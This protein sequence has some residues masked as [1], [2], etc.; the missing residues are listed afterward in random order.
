MLLALIVIPRGAE[1][2]MLDIDMMG[3]TKTKCVFTLKGLP[4][5]KKNGKRTPVLEFDNFKED[6]DLCPV[7]S[8]IEYCCLT[9]PFRRTNKETSLF[10]A[11]LKPHMA[12]SKSSI[13]RWLKDVLKWAGI[14][15]KI[16]QAHS[17]RAAATS[18]AFMKGLSV[19][20]IIK[21][22]NWSQES[23]WQRFYNKDI[24]SVSATFQEKVLGGL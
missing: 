20:D 17:V 8:L 4:K 12:V 19:P 9:E 14:D 2:T 11:L 24:K 15:T 23:T 21:K 18:K 3:L 13:A 7:K 1:T 6:S 22:G 10:L 16:Y 5:N